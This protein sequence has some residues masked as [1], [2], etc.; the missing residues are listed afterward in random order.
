MLHSVKLSFI[1]VE[2]H[3]IDDI[4]ICQ[5]SILE[6]LS[7]KIPYELIVSSNSIYSQSKQKELVEA[8]NDLKWVFNEKNGGFAYA[9]N[10]GL[11][12]ANGDV[13]I[14]MNP[15]VRMRSNLEL[16]LRYLI[17]ADSIGVIAPK[18]RN[19]Q[20]EIQDS[21]RNF[22]TPDRFLLR[23]IGRFTSPNKKVGGEENPKEVD[24]VIGAFMMMTRKS[25]ELTKG[26]D[27]GYFLYC[28][29]MDFCK[30]VYQKGYSVVYYPSVE[31]EYQGTRSA[32]HSLKYAIIF[33]KSLLRYWMKF[34]VF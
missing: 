3:S 19:A 8:Y 6:N 17:S 22:I 31:I 23:H 28:E 14:I 7:L 5:D 29:D 25:Y 4:L 34:G 32:R 16:M 2:Y 13:L 27:E 11:K 9:M 21:F 26:F 20:G 30:R 12:V 10:Q 18:I 15:D 24:W 33:F 1:I